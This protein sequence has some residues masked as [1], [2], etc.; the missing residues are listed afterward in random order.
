M[1]W[2]LCSKLTLLRNQIIFPDCLGSWMKINRL[3][4]KPVG[5]NGKHILLILTVEVWTVNKSF[6]N[7]I[8]RKYDILS[9]PSSNYWQTSHFQNKMTIKYVNKLAFM[10]LRR[11]WMENAYQKSFMPATSLTRK[12]ELMILCAKECSLLLY[13]KPNLATGFP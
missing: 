4:L 9:F 6:C 5:L 1:F 7:T 13:S 10:K 12:I 2:G 11:Y 3:L 8:H